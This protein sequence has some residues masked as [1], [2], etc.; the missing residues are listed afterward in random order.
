MG[1]LDRGRATASEELMSGP[2]EVTSLTGKRHCGQCI[3]HTSSARAMSPAE[4]AEHKDGTTA[5]SHKELHHGTVQPMT[6]FLLC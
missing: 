1:R 4:V 6:R 5:F 3:P 2:W